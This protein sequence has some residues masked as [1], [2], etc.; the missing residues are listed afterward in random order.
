[1]TPLIFRRTILG[2][3][4]FMSCIGCGKSNSGPKLDP[5]VQATISGSV[6]ND[7]KPLPV[8]C[9]VYFASK[10][11]GTTAAGKL[12]VLGNFS[13]TPPD[14][15]QGLTAGRYAVMV[16]PPAVDQVAPS[17]S[18]PNYKDFMMNAGKNTAPT[19]DAGIPQAFM[20]LETTKLILEVKPGPNNFV[21]DLA[22]IQ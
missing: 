8:N 7:G 10:V 17:A 1:M 15:K 21:I 12:D 22:K 3:C 20:S 16:R 14:P 4:F 5:S 6:V 18:D 11:T 13:A 19:S 2:L 9:S